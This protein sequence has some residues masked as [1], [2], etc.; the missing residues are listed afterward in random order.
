RKVGRESTSPR[1]NWIFTGI[2]TKTGLELLTAS[3]HSIGT[4][5]FVFYDGELSQ[6]SQG[7]EIPY[8]RKTCT[9][10]GELQ[11][12]GIARGTGAAYVSLQSN[13]QI[14]RTIRD[15][16]LIA[17]TGR[18]VI[19]DVKIDYSKRT[20]FT[21]GVV[22]VNLGRFPLGEKFRFIGRALVRMITG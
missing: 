22:G 8:R 3:A 17:D 18:P 1:N 12:E 5:I 13:D 14:E 10:L 11:L 20:R 9:I 4:V 2:S 16:F 7:Q 15:A 21:K 19:V 6:I